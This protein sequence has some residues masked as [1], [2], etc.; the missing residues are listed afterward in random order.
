MLYNRLCNKM[1]GRKCDKYFS[2]GFL[3]SYT[4]SLFYLTSIACHSHSYTTH[5]W[6][7]GSEG[8]VNMTSEPAGCDIRYLSDKITIA[9]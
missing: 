4:D 3:K 9:H 5:V 8:H 6:T 2:I 7:V 1:K